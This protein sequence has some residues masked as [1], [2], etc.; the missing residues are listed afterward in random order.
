MAVSDD[1]LRLGAS[2]GRTVRMYMYTFVGGGWK[3]VDEMRASSVAPAEGRNQMIWNHAR[4]V[5]IIN[6]IIINRVGGGGVEGSGRVWIGPWW[7][8]GAPATYR[9]VQ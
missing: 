2:K 4:D 9:G 3:C 7:C 8:D 6:I 5:I 1:P